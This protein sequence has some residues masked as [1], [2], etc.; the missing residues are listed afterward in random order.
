MKTNQSLLKTTLRMLTLVFVFII[1]ACSKDEPTSDDPVEPQFSSNEAD[2]F[3]AAVANLNGFNQS[4]ESSIV[5]T[6][7]TSPERVGTTEFECSTQNFEGA[8]GFNELFMLDPTTDVIYPGSMLKG[9]TIP[10]GEYSRINVDRAPITMSISLSNISG[11]PSVTV[12]DPNKLSEVRAGINELLNREV[13]G[14]TPALLT[15]DESEVFSEEQLSVALG[16]NYRDRTKDISGSFDFNTT[17]TKRK[18]VLKFIQRYF[19]LDLD[20]PGESPSDLFV[21]LPSIESLGSTSPVYVSSVTY[22]RMVLYTVE[23]ESSITEVKTAFEAAIEAG[24]KGGSFEL[25]VDSEK[26]LENS[27][28]KALIIGGSGASAA[29]TV[30]GDSLSKIYEFIAEGGNYSQ[31]SPGAPIAYKLSFV[32]QGFPAARVVLATEYQVRNCDVAYPEYLV[33]IKSITTTQPSDIEL[34]GEVGI[35]MIVGGVPLDINNNDF[36]DGPIWKKNRDNFV[37]VQNDKPLNFPQD[38]DDVQP[39]TLR[40][41]RPDMTN[42]YIECY[43]ELFDDNGIFGFSRLGNHMTDADDDKLR[44][45]DLEL[46][47]E[48]EIVLDDFDD[49]VEVTFTVKRTL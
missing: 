33:T 40:P 3:N 20:S 2:E 35:R 47:D 15:L 43:G 14:A 32:K 22:G 25:D 37:D 11:K 27:S 1:C 46:N 42:D 9:E 4:S 44:L 10:T 8:P 49:Q 34:Y 39:Y 23:S 26:I 19:T 48:K 31:D 17:T 16:A 28:I 6:A 41:Y 21:D 38:D 29:Q 18:Y 36:R 5:E 7:S 30:G 12:N 45:K 24:E 13:T